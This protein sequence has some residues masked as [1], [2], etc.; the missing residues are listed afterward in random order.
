LQD[1]EGAVVLVSHDRHLL[2]TVVDEFRLVAHGRA[3]P[4]DGDLEDYARWLASSSATAPAPA[5]PSAPAPVAAESA[6]AR[7]QRKRAEAQQ[8]AALGPMRAAIAEHER[9]LERLSA[10]RLRLERELLKASTA[11]DSGRIPKLL[12]EQ[13]RVAR[14]IAAVESAWVRSSEQLETLLSR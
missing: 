11:A 10:E 6:E 5:S 1:Y 13:A 14:S 7:K 4:F 3:E 2:S 8:R 9:E 12:Q